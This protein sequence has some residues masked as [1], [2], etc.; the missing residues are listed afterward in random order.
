MHL[1]RYSYASDTAIAKLLAD[2]RENGMPEAISRNSRY[3]ER[4]KLCGQ[5]T[6]YGKVV[7]TLELDVGGPKTV[8]IGVQNP[9]AMLLVACKESRCLSQVIRDTMDKYEFPWHIIWYSDG[10]SPSHNMTKKDRRKAV[11]IYWSFAEF[12]LD[13]LYHEQAWFTVTTC[14]QYDVIN[15]LARG[16]PRLYKLILGQLFLC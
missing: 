14:R 4:K 2:I 10:V 15:K 5:I 12:G 1:G 3:R 7:E 16:L 13:I 11:A 8:S 9:M 6:K